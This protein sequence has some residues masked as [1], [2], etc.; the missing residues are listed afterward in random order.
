MSSRSEIED[1]IQ[2]SRNDWVDR[3]LWVKPKDSKNWEVVGLPTKD[4]IRDGYGQG[5]YRYDTIR[6]RREQERGKGYK[7]TDPLKE[8]YT[9]EQIY[10]FRE[11]E[12]LKAVDEVRN[13]PEIKRLLEKAEGYSPDKEKL[14]DFDFQARKIFTDAERKQVRLLHKIE[15]RV[16]IYKGLTKRNSGGEVVDLSHRIDLGNLKE[17]FD[18]PWTTSL[19]PEEIAIRKKKIKEANKMLAV[20]APNL[21]VVGDDIS[22][23]PESYLPNLKNVG[24]RVEI[25]LDDKSQLNPEFLNKLLPNLEKVGNRIYIRISAPESVSSEGE[26]KDVSEYYIGHIVHGENESGFE[27]DTSKP[28]DD[29][30]TIDRVNPF[31]KLKYLG[32]REYESN[33]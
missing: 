12:F 24:G 1:L 15:E 29:D 25:Y 2:F 28:W 18:V 19:F 23:F 9:E 3:E 21:T 16:K 4:S 32:I 31:K 22:V 13:R 10:N 26:T 7:V 8:I 5:F 6:T 17:I 14:G 27:L 20:S 30:E 11:K 33:H